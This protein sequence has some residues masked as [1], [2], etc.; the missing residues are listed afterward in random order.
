MHSLPETEDCWRYTAAV[1]WPHTPAALGLV[2]VQMGCCGSWEDE[3]KWWDHLWILG[4]TWSR[5]LK[6]WRCHRW[7]SS[8]CW[9]V[10]VLRSD[11]PLLICITVC[12][13]CTGH[14]LVTR[15]VYPVAGECRLTCA[16]DRTLSPSQTSS[17]QSSA[18]VLCNWTLTNNPTWTQIHR[19]FY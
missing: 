19:I 11:K 17:P 9:Y 15:G 12:G 13:K 2:A 14:V 3:E 5:L 1:W 8:V 18:S 4:E 6:C 10:I 16:P 7:L